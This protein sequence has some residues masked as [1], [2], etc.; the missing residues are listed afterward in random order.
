M[1]LQT[2][3]LIENLTNKIK[4]ALDQP[5]DEKTS[6]EEIK[7]RFAKNIATAIGQEVDAWIKTGQVTTPAGVAVQVTPTSGTGATTAPG[8]GTIS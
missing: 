3:V 8:I 6:S 4:D 2:N 7:M 5:F 1:A